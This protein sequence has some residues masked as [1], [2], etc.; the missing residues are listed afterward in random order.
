MN[1]EVVGLKNCCRRIPSSTEVVLGQCRGGTKSYPRK[2]AARVGQESS[3]PWS[4][5][6]SSADVRKA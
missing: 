4:V 1:S 5:S 2:R 6:K 3:H